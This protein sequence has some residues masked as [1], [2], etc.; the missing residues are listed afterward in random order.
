[1]SAKIKS[2]HRV[3]EDEQ[4]VDQSVRIFEFHYSRRRSAPNIQDVVH[5]WEE[6]FGSNRDVDS[7]NVK[8]H[9]REAFIDPCNS[10]GAIEGVSRVRFEI[11][12]HS[13]SGGGNHNQKRS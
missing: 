13:S 1:M 8:K 5:V 9:R 3:P 4:K 7:Q 10:L 11:E 2:A 6:R 12:K